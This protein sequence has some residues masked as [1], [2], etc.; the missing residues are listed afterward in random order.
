MRGL[1]WM[2]WMVGVGCTATDGALD[3]GGLGDGSAASDA[4]DANSSSDGTV[5][6]T[7]LRTA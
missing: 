6:A 7:I 2:A 3:T 4:S 1:W 5:N